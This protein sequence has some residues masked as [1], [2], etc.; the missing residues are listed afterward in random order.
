MLMSSGTP[1]P[2]GGDGRLYRN[3]VMNKRQASPTGSPLQ[4]FVRAKKRINDIYSGMDDYVADVA[5]FVAGETRRAGVPGQWV[6]ELF[7][8]CIL[9]LCL[10]VCANSVSRFCVTF[11]CPVSLPLTPSNPPTL[12]LQ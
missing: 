12:P 7:A 11:P 6:S 1:G 3:P 4:L 5:R 2:G 8:G 10:Y 9:M